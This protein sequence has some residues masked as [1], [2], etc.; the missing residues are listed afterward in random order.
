MNRGYG[1]F[2]MIDLAF[3][4]HRCLEKTD[5]AAFPRRDLGRLTLGWDIYFGC[6]GKAGRIF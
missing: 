4:D 2:H 6:I 1:A 5:S 3:S